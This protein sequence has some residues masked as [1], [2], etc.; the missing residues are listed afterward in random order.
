MGGAEVRSESLGDQSNGS[1]A[2]PS[3][4][5]VAAAAQVTPQTR[6]P[7][8]PRTAASTTDVPMRD[9]NDRA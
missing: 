1:R 2:R 9:Q 3:V 6:P 8:L 7:Q 5:W 4:M